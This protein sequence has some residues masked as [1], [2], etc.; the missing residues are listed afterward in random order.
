MEKTNFSL[1]LFSI[2]LFLTLSS[3][4]YL[5][6]VG[7]NKDDYVQNY[8]LF[9]TEVQANYQNYDAEQ[10]KNADNKMQQFS[11]QQFERFEQE[12]N[13]EE[14]LELGKFPIMYH[15]SKYKQLVDERVKRV[16][17]SEG[18]MLVRHL[19]EIMDSTYTVYDGFDSNLRDL[20]FRLK[21]EHEQ[22]GK[23]R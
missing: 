13:F 23:R 20:L 15:L 6:Y 10:W 16:Y 22:K 19:T 21:C 7:M 17:E 11:H 2:L 5:E 14:R 4:Q 3:C 8:R 1:F 18:Q 9:L 12:L